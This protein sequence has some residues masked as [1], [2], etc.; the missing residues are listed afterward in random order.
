[1]ENIDDQQYE[2]IKCWFLNEQESMYA[3]AK[4]LADDF[5]ATRRL[6]RRGRS[7]DQHGQLNI[8]VRKRRKGVGVEIEYYGVRF[9]GNKSRT[10]TRHAIRKGKSDKYTMASMNS[11]PW[12]NLTDWEW[13]WFREN[14]RKF[15]RIRAS[16]KALTRLSRSFYFYQTSRNKELNNRVMEVSR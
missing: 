16:S 11:L 10:F 2:D 1:M 5:Y 8:R 15:A 4:Y 14:E 13:E 7:I 6:V 9:H 3:A 12:L